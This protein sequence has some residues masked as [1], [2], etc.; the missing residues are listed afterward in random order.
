MERVHYYSHLQ[1]ESRTQEVL[2]ALPKAIHSIHSRAGSPTLISLSSA[3]SQAQAK[4]LS[5]KPISHSDFLTK[6]P[7]SGG[8]KIM[9]YRLSMPPTWC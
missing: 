6:M 4:V 3:T 2:S 7:T 1:K 8:F 9:L 5:H